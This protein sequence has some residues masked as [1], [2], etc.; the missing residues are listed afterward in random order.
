PACVLVGFA[1]MFIQM[2]GYYHSEEIER[3]T[4]TI[5]VVP[6]VFNPVLTLYFIHPY[7]KIVANLIPY[8]TSSFNKERST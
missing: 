8:R 7:R 1:F 6:A 4:Y 3:M 5:A 2:A